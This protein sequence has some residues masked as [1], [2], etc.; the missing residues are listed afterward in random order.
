M[1]HRVE[2]IRRT[3]VGGKVWQGGTVHQVDDGTLRQLIEAGAV[4]IKMEAGAPENKAAPRKRGR[5]RKVKP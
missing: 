2:I 3:V 5:P 4:E 1:M